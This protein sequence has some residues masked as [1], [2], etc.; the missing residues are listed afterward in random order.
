MASLLCLN[1]F[2][3]CCCVILAKIIVITQVAVGKRNLELKRKKRKLQKA[4]KRKKFSQSTK[5]TPSI[6]TDL[7]FPSEVMVAPCHASNQAVVSKVDSSTTACGEDLVALEMRL[8]DSL[9]PE[10]Q[11]YSYEYLKE[12]RQRLCVQVEQYRNEVE[13]LSSALTEQSS[14]HRRQLD[15]VRDFYRTIAYS[16]TRSG[17]MVKKSLENSSSAAELMKELDAQYSSN[18]NM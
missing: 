17:A 5:D 7:S 9:Q 8:E 2:L 15:Q 6:A 12:C 11:A 10:D 13:R 1:C 16:R 18:C 14:Q 3:S 4:R